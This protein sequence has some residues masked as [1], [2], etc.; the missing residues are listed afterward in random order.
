MF[1]LKQSICHP[2]YNV[3][4][5]EDGVGYGN[6]YCF[7]IDGASCLSGNN[8]V[9]TVSDASWMV[10]N[11][12]NGLCALLD[13]GDVRSTK[14]ILREVIAPLREKYLDALKKRGMDAPSDSP[15]AC[16]ALFRKR[17]GKLEFFGL[18]DCVGTAKFHNGEVFW[19]LDEK[20]P[21]LDEQVLKKMSL[22]SKQ[23]GISVSEAKKLCNDMLLKNR[24]LKNKRGGYWIL[25]LLTDDGIDNAR[26][27]IF[28][29]TEPVSV[30]AFSDGFA[31]LTEVFKV[32]ENYTELFEAM[33][34]NDLEKLFRNL[35]D[36]QDADADCNL[37]PRFKL[38]DDTCALWGVFDP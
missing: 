3:R 18:G 35:C 13:K 33:M 23:T 19:S 11:V 5:N 21:S 9:D 32:Y 22:I 8:A 16:F 31:Q 7:V 4:A 25:D 34:K 30:G 14:E 1:D 17:N 10:K 28:E 36:L 29:L 26:E 15:S 12:V 27:S 6:D 37:Y 24:S 38:R 2:G 20:L